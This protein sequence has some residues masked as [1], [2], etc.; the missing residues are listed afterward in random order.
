MV[1]SKLY[2]KIKLFR[3]NGT[4]TIYTNV[5][6]RVMTPTP[7]LNRINKETGLKTSRNLTNARTN[8]ERA[9]VRE[10]ARYYVTIGKLKE[11]RKLVK[12]MSP[13]ERRRFF[14]TLTV[15][16]LIAYFTSIA[17]PYAR[18]MGKKM[19][20]ASLVNVAVNTE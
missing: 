2:K 7:R 8:D 3:N 17:G 6:N 11:V 20:K 19:N 1:M 4:P 5:R 9:Y 15:P 12:S 13:P 16:Q 10:V 18:M 14:G